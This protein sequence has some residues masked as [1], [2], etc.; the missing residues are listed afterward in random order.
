M[1]AIAPILTA[2]DEA[3]PFVILD[4]DRPGREMA[5]K[6]KTSLYQKSTASI[7][8][9]AD[10]YNLADTEIEDL[11]PHDL[12]VPIITRYLPRR[13]EDFSDG[14]VENSPIIPQ[15]EA[16][17]KKY[18]IELE[19]GWKVE[20]AKLVKARMLKH[21]SFRIDEETLKIWKDLFI[22]ID[23]ELPLSSP[24]LKKVKHA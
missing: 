16:Y 14:G 22:K 5:N 9:I 2:K 19:L 1:T 8:L 4:S 17:A 23:A 20:I 11:F 12:I 15:V 18:D 21:N 3:L 24:S 7:I 10:V 13:D 6:L